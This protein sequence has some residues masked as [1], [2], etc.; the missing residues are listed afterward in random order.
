MTLERAIS[1]AI[2]NS[3]LVPLLKA[4]TT[5]GEITK[6]R[7]RWAAIQ[8]VVQ[9]RTQRAVREELGVGIATA[10]RAAKAVRDHGSVVRSVV[11]KQK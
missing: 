10:T 6:I 1:A 5:P 3:Q 11:S 4:L 8:L 2:E 9:G 7:N